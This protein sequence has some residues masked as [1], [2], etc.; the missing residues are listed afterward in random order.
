M[1]LHPVLDQ[2]LELLR[3]V[4]LFSSC[5]RG[6]LRSIESLTTIQDVPA[7]K[8]L[9][10]QGAA[11]REFFV[12]V[13]GAAVVF[14]HGLEIARIGPGSFFGEL[15]LLDGG[16]RTATVVADTEMVLAVLSRSDFKSLQLSA[17][18][19]AY[20]LLAEVGQRL[21]GIYAMLSAESLTTLTE[22]RS[23]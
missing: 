13:D 10:K 11:G 2:R 15:A 5:T 4:G 12:I 9:T 6:E 22:L 19:V 3:G 14:R 17:P 23:L 20:K 16:E 8:V 1:V 18:S 21:R 7:G